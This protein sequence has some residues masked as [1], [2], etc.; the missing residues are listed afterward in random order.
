MVQ[1]VAN[2]YMLQILANL[3]TH[4]EPRNQVL[5]LKVIQN[6][7]R[8]GIPAEIFE[9]TILKVKSQT[10]RQAA[11]EIKSSVNFTSQFLGYWCGHLHLI[12]EAMF[13]ETKVTSTGSYEVS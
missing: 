4:C 6:L 2:P 7:I 8:M 12:R 9:D 11:F 13:T 1:R 10:G 5:V 3:F